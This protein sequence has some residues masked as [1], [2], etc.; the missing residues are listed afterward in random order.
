M[1]QT[2]RLAEP[3]HHVVIIGAGVGGR[4]ARAALLAAGVTDVVMLDKA[5]G[6][7][8]DG[9]LRPGQEVLSSRFDDDTD[10]WLLTTAGG[11]TFQAH[12]VIAAYRPVQVPWLPHITGRDDFRGVSFHA[13]QWDPAFDPHGKRIAVIGADAIAGHHIGRL[14]ESAASVTVFAHSPRRIV[15]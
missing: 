3:C 14:T 9:H 10:T 13:A 12:V 8:L 5:P 4:S 1:T 7:A 6:P 15:A 11:E 2:P